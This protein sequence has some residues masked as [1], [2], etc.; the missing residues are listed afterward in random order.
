MYLVVPNIKTM[1]KTLLILIPFLAL[2]FLTNCGA[3]KTTPT[4]NPL[5]TDIGVTINGITWATRNVDAPGTFAANPEDAGMFF[6][7]NRRK[8]WN[9]VDR[10]ARDW[11]SSY[12]TGTKWYAESDPCPEGW[13]VPTRDE[14][15]S[16]VSAGSEWTTFNRINGR[17]FGIAPYQIFLPA[18]GARGHDTGRLRSAGRA[19]FYGSSTQHDSTFAWNLSFGRAVNTTLNNRRA[20]GFSIR[21]VKKN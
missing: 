1:N 2:A 12:P 14:L 8:G 9:A 17:L 20:G 6:Q 21:C 7:W 16:L 18:A 4:P 13:R 19:G 11:D 3:R 5:T 15:N 10:R